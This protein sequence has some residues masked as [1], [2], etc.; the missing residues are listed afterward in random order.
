MWS[1]WEISLDSPCEPIPGRDEQVRNAV[2]TPHDD[3]CI[4]P[5][6]TAFF[7]VGGWR[8]EL[9]GYQGPYRNDHGYM[10]ALTEVELGGMSVLQKASPDSIGYNEDVSAVG[11]R[12]NILTLNKNN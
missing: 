1:K 5:L 7:F 11:W 6:V 10:S 3:Y 9:D 2:H 12:G 8:W 4:G